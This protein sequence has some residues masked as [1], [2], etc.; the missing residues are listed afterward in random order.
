MNSL[1][2]LE[3]VQ[4]LGFENKLRNCGKIKLI[5]SQRGITVVHVHPNIMI[6]V[7]TGVHQI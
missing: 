6:H 1:D 5:C 4:R 3:G 7:D 2:T